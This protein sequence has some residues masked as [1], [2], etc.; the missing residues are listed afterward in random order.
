MNEI[1]DVLDTYDELKAKWVKRFGT[2]DGFFEWWI[3]Q[4]EKQNG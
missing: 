1:Q 3:E 2:E 4:I